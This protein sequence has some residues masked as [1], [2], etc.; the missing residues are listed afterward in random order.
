MDGRQFNLQFDAVGRPKAMWDNGSQ[1]AP[2]GWVTNVAYNE[3]GL[4]TAM[5]MRTTSSGNLATESRR[6]NEI[7][8]LL[9]ISTSVSCGLIV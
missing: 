5:T 1:T 4:P 8:Q 6:Y 7:G 2:D 9:T 3:A